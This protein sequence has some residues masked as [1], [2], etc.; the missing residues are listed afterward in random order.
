MVKKQALGKKTRGG[1]RNYKKS[2]VALSDLKAVLEK[3]AVASGNPHCFHFK[4]YYK[5][6]RCSAV[7]AM[8]LLHMRNILLEFL[9]LSLL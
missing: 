8:D 9:Q 1:A 6:T 2:Q 3:H 5:K 4:S 7:V